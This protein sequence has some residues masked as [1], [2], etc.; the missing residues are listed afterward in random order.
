MLTVVTWLWRRPGGP[1]F[2]ARYVNRLR[3]ML[4]RHLRLDH[5]LACVTD[6]PEGL[7]PDVRVVAPPKEYAATPRC[8]RRMWQW[9]ADRARDFGSR[10]LAIDLDVVIVRD[11]TPIIDR[12]EPLVAWR[13]GYAGVFS[14]SFIL[15]D[16]GALDGA[17]AAFRDDPTGFP[18][19][20]GEKHASDQA[21]LNYWIRH[22]RGPRAKPIAQ[23]TEADGFV[24]WF[25]AGYEKLEHRGMGPGHPDLPADARIVVMGSADK[26]VL[27][28]GRY[29]WVREHW[30]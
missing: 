21:M 5:E 3:S 26:A 29:P 22:G 14:G 13:V 8:R 24:T 7:H 2:D 4:E 9:S 1:G 17:W 20:T 6:E 11:L 23:W 12:P 16:V 10:M 30:R 27:D 28:E 25:G 18:A 15:A 19:R